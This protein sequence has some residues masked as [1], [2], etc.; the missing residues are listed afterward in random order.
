[1]GLTAQGAESEPGSSFAAT[2]LAARRPRPSPGRALVHPQERSP[3]MPRFGPG[4][5]P[6]E[7]HGALLVVN[8][9]L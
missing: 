1:M 3:G 2:R 5:A 6:V 4:N 7:N 8:Q 9:S